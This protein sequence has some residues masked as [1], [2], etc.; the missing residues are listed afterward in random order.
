MKESDTWKRSKANKQHVDGRADEFFCLHFAKFE[1]Q[2]KPKP[3]GAVP[4]L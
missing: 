4:K 3:L 1:G 2:Q